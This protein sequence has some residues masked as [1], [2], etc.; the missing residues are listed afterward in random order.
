MTPLPV[1][2]PV[3]G[4]AHQGAW[5]LAGIAAGAFVDRP[6]FAGM[7][8]GPL[9]V[10]F[11]AQLAVGEYRSDEA[12]EA[13]CGLS[14]ASKRPKIVGGAL[15]LVWFCVLVGLFVTVRTTWPVWSL[16]AAAGWLYWPV[17]R[18]SAAGINPRRALSKS[19]PLRPAVTVHTVAS[20]APGAGAR[21]LEAVATEAD[22]RG[23][24]LH[25]VAANQTLEQ[26]YRRFGF[27][28]SGNPV[29]M[30]SGEAAV[31]MTRPHSGQP[32]AER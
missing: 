30:P 17:V 16:F 11:W 12:G 18:D 6:Q 13:V 3:A 14:G 5:H 2:D 22:Q 28:P 23:W 19:R 1:S 29:L 10:M 4:R 24:V 31:P 21:L 32:G 20:S 9:R 25:L 8:R 26:Y 15:A 27:R 7:R